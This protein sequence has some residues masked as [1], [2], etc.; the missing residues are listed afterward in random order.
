M[1]HGDTWRVRETNLRLGAA[2]AE[3]EGLYSALLRANSP[4]RHV[5]LRADLACAARRVA[6][7]AILPAGQRPP[8]PVARN[9]RWRRRRR[10]AA[11]GAAWIAARYGQE[12]Q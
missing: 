2:I 7:L 11:R 9:S 10:L 8:A 1:P 6:A 5:Q 3:V 12:T 4:E